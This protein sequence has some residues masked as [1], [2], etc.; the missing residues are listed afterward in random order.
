M[1]GQFEFIKTNKA[2]AAIGPYSQAVRAGDTIY[3]SGQLGLDPKSGDLVKGGIA[4]QVGQV[5]ENIRAILQA[6]GLDLD[7]VVKT[8]VFLADMNE[9]AEMND[10]YAGFFKDN[11]PARETVQ[12]ARLPKDARVEISCVAIKRSEYLSDLL[13][14]KE[15]TLQTLSRLREREQKG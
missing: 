7:Q 14:Q 9:F 4:V 3:V 15:K 8:T 13:P 10:V 12:V 5:L 1:P 2:P 11:P 6:A